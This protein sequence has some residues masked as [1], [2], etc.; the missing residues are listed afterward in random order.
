M[1]I[2][3]TLDFAHL[4]IHTNYRECYTYFKDYR[5]SRMIYTGIVVQLFFQ[6][7]YLSF[8]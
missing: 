8:I 1:C 3:H 4:E 2:V 5:F 7:S 6:V